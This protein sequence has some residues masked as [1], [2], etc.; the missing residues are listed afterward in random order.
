MRIIKSIYNSFYPALRFFYS[1]LG[2]EGN[3]P[4]KKDSTHL[5]IDLHGNLNVD[6]NNKEVQKDISKQIKALKDME[7]GKAK[8]F[9]KRN[10]VQAE[11]KPRGDSGQSLKP[12]LS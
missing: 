9:T 10:A 2:V 7:E 1:V 5:F 8:G 3:T 11:S 12:K 4:N 6:F